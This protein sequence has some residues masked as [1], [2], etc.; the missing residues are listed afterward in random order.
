V[1]IPIAP[2]EVAQVLNPEGLPA[3]DGPVGS[4]EGTVFVFGADPPTRSG[5]NLAKCPEAV[6][7][8]GPLFRAGAKREDGKRPL[9]DA[10]V[11]IIGY[12]G[13]YLPEKAPVRSLTLTRCEEA[14]RTI[15]MTFGQAL[16]IHNRTSLLMAPFFVEALGTSVLAA[17]P[18]GAPVRVYTTKPGRFSLAD[19]LGND[20]VFGADVYV[21]LQPLHATTDVR[22]H[23][24]IDGVPAV[25]NLQ[26]F[27]RLPA[28]GKEVSAPITVRA[29]VV[30][31]IELTLPFDGSTP[32]AGSGVAGPGAR[33]SAGPGAAARVDGGVRASGPTRSRP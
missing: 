7:T 21:M 28:I 3:Y 31:S 8:R 17:P 10:I 6:R 23:F 27:A 22:G 32:L 18:R 14:P 29:G 9:A 33:P 24:R 26:V 13:F 1:G 30:E 12:E 11:G 2:A 15:D 16:E 20:D 19:R 5:L 4:I 25:P